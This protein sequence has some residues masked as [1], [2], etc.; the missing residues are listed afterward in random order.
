VVRPLVLLSLTVG[1]LLAACSFAL[2][3]GTAYS[4]SSSPAPTLPPDVVT[5]QRTAVDPAGRAWVSART[6]R[7]GVGSVWYYEGSAWRSLPAPPKYTAGALAPLTIDDVW[8]AGGSKLVHWDGVSWKVASHP[9][10]AGLDVLDMAAAAPDD[11]W[12]VGTRDGRLARLPGDGTGERE[13]LQ[14]PVALHWNGTSWRV[15]VLPTLPGIDQRLDAVACSSDEVY[16]V[17]RSERLANPEDVGS[18]SATPEFKDAPVVLRRVA[19]SWRRVHHANYGRTGTVLLD[20]SVLPD[21]AP[22]VLG[23]VTAS[24]PGD[25]WDRW[26]TLVD[27]RSGGKWVIRQKSAY[28]WRAYPRA[29]ATGSAEDVWV[30]YTSKTDDAGVE[31]WDGRAWT[32]T[33]AD[34]MGWTPGLGKVGSSI[35]DVAADKS[36]AWVLGGWTTLADE[37]DT[38]GDPLI[39]RHDASGWAKITF[40]MQ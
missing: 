21:G 5:L 17:G 34:E 20:V 13:R 25:R 27:E 2:A 36:S 29:I 16:A 10:V 32:L 3:A 11:V 38:V 24:K 8:V 18:S 1:A 6:A 4:S 31:H 7:S 33:S 23:M 28:R 30:V 22:W 35:P 9:R 12:A 19:G 14:K 39:W 26:Y 40:A 37:S 15:S